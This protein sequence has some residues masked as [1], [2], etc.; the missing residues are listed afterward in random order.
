MLTMRIGRTSES[1]TRREEQAKLLETRDSGKSKALCLSGLLSD[2]GRGWPGRSNRQVR[3]T[4]RWRTRKPKGMTWEAAVRNQQ[5]RS[6]SKATIFLH[7]LLASPKKTLTQHKRQ[8]LPQALHQPQIRPPRRCPPRQPKR[9]WACPAQCLPPSLHLQCCPVQH[10]A[11]RPFLLGPAARDLR[12]ALSR[13]RRRKA[14]SMHGPR[15]PLPF[16]KATS[17]DGLDQKNVLLHPT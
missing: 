7:R 3:K 16:P 11:L 17:V 13:I 1:L 6:S 10:P 4:R 5:G 14:V 12:Q 2:R 15:L 9:N 8:D